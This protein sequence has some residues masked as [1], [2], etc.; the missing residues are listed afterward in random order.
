[1]PIQGIEPYQ[2][3]TPGC[4]EMADLYVYAIYM[5][6][7]NKTKEWFK[8]NPPQWWVRRA[9]MADGMF[10]TLYDRMNLRNIEHDQAMEMY[11]E[12]TKKPVLFCPWCGK[13]MPA[14]VLNRPK[15]KVGVHDDDYCK[16]CKRRNNECRCIRPELMWGT[17]DKE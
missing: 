14:L 3:V 11:S 8:N 15:I 2:Y 4:C 17:D 9:D 5:N 7:Y 13:A 1:M 10:S 16:T 6:P 12:A